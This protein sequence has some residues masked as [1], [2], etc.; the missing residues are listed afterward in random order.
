[1]PFPSDEQ[2]QV[3]DHRG[4]PLVVI[5]G[6]GTGKTKTIVE[7]ML[8]LLRE[9]A[10]RTVSFVTFTRTSRSDTFEKLERT[11][12]PE[13]VANPEGSTPRVGTLHASARS[14]L[15]QLA[16]RVDFDSDFTILNPDKD[17]RALLVNDVIADLELGYSADLIDRAVLSFL[18]NLR[19]SDD[20]RISEEL[21][22]ALFA[23]YEELLHFYNALG[24]EEIVFLACQAL[25]AGTD[26]IPPQFLQVDEYQDLNPADQRLVHL[27]A[28]NTESQVVVVGDDAQSIYEFRFANPEGLRELWNSDD[29]T[30]IRLL[31]CFRLPAH[32]QRAATALIENEDYLGSVMN[33][34]PDNGLSVQVFQCTRSEYQARI[35]GRKI[36]DFVE[37]GTTQDG[38]HLTY[39]DVMILCPS[40]RFI[41]GV[42]E[43]LEQ[44]DIPSKHIHK[45]EVPGEI[46]R[47]IL[48]IRMVFNHDN[49][50]L[51]QWMNI[52]GLSQA[53]IHEIRR[54]AMTSGADL[55]AHCRAIDDQEIRA[56]LDAVEV[57]NEAYGGFESFIATLG[58]FPHLNLDQDQVRNA[59]EELLVDGEMPSTSDLI[60]SLYRFYG[61]LEDESIASE[62]NA[63]RIST[64]HSSKGLEGELVCL[65][66]MNRSYMPMPGRNPQGERRLLYV[67]MTRAKQDL[68]ISFHERYD[69]EEGYLKRAAMSPFLREISDHLTITRIRAADLD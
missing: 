68:I 29:W 13:A 22:R 35:V 37:E 65:M 3:L 51:R 26:E 24:M 69:A 61:V 15:H 59:L 10:D 46:W 56:I 19:H 41:P 34:K 11:L 66:W 17:E 16:W 42:V 54:E 40:S 30:T 48:L 12:S 63:V 60:P 2:R 18:C 33:S 23:R 1:L 49:V 62:E 64:L 50:A 21:Q 57:T 44:Q 39:S 6:P 28:S 25:E 45:P 14:V 9:N 8:G 31:D 67:G 38:D 32:I 53:S 55:F 47:L 27:L 7:R 4:Q 5:A 52:A 20:M 58:A 43:E 36:R